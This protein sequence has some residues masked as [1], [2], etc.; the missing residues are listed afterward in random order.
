[1]SKNLG[2]GMA[3]LVLVGAVIGQI[4]GPLD[5]FTKTAFNDTAHQK[6]PSSQVT[7]TLHNTGY[8]IVETENLDFAKTRRSQLRIEVDGPKSES[9][10]RAICEN[11]FISHGDLRFRNAVEFL[12]YLPGT[13]IQ[14]FFTAGQAIW[15][16]DGK[17][18]NA[19]LVVAGDNHRHQLTIKVGNAIGNRIIIDEAALPESMKRK[20]FYELVKT[21]DAGVGDTEAYTL[22]A[23][24]Y[25]LPEKMIY[26]IAGEGAARGWIMP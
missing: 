12:F 1:M 13:D 17:W 7:A 15:A 24:K 23:R 14:R 6:K 11:I 22:M 2:L 18:E 9:D 16:P 5:S 19:N 3:L 10:L 25:N 26:Q 4:V 20:I 21:Q 8:R